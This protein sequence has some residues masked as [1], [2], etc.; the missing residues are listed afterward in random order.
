MV[1]LATNEI[2]L[3]MTPPKSF[4]LSH[5][6]QTLLLFFSHDSKTFLNATFIGQ[7]FLSFPLLLIPSLTRHK[8]HI[9]IFYES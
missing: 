6:F 9:N 1:F 8:P 3:S 5:S 4:F 2:S 7:L